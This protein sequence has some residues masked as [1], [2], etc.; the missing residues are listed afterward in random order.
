MTG[1]SS[2]PRVTVV[3]GAYNCA[4]T[5]DEALQSLVDQT[6]AEWDLVVCD[7]AS[8]DGTHERLLHWRD[9]L[10]DGRVTVLRNPVNAKLAA[11]LNRCLAHATG[12]LVARMDGD[13]V[14][15][16]DRFE[17]QVRYL[18]THAD[19]DLVGTAMRRFDV[20]G[21]ADVVSP[22]P[23]PDRWSLR[24]GVPF[25]HATIV[26][27]REVFDAVGGYRVAPRTERTED[28]DLWFR[29]FDQGFTGRNLAEPL[30]LVREDAS[31]IRRRTVRTRLN[32]MLVQLEGYRRLGYP[33]RW[34]VH[35]VLG[36]AKAA[37]PAP[38]VGAY[39][40]MQKWLSAKRSRDVS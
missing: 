38:A 25:C 11:T 40:N 24:T 23:A 16:P 12:P 33:R 8:T 1:L 18:Q 5:L 20:A 4:A 7:D 17:R 31:A 27:R 13:D 19:V 22:P 21:L 3:M 2:M 10:G 34:Y 29:F 30:Y 39:R 6:Y 28:L 26:A 36:V 32:V 37:V 35:P 15:V 14:C 9:L